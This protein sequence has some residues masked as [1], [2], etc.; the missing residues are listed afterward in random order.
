MNELKDALGPLLTTQQGFGFI[1]VIAGATIGTLI[2][3]SSRSGDG[4]VSATEGDSIA[5]LVCLGMIA[6]GLACL[7]LP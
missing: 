6:V 7:A 4:S 2:A 3:S 5:L 1:L